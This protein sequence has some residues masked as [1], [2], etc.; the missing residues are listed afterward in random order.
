M[1][2]RKPKLSLFRDR[3]TSDSWTC[4]NNNNNPNLLRTLHRDKKREEDSFSSDVSDSPVLEPRRGKKSE[5]KKT[6][7]D[8]DL[9][10][11]PER[12][13]R[14]W[15]SANDIALSH[16]SNQTSP[17][18]QLNAS[19][20]AIPPE[21]NPNI[22]TIGPREISPSSSA[23]DASTTISREKR[24]AK[25]LLHLHIQ[26]A[27]T[28]ANNVG[29]RK[30]DNFYDSA[31][32]LKRTRKRS[33]NAIENGISKENLKQG[34]K[35][36]EK[37]S[38]PILVHYTHNQLDEK[39]STSSS[40][41]KTKPF[42]FIKKP[43]RGRS[44]SLPEKIWNDFLS[45]TGQSKETIPSA[46]TNTKKKIS[47]DRKQAQ[48]L[49]QQL[50]KS[51]RKLFG[52]MEQTP[53]NSFDKSPQDNSGRKEEN[54]YGDVRFA[55]KYGMSSSAEKATSKVG[56]TKAPRKISETK[57]PEVVSSTSKTSR[58]SKSKQ[59][60]VKPKNSE[61]VS[62]SN[63]TN[64]K[65][66]DKKA[67]NQP[68]KQAVKKDDAKVEAKHTESKKRPE[69]KTVPK[70]Q[71]Q[72]LKNGETL[73]K[74]KS[75]Q[76]ENVPDV[77]TRARDSDLRENTAAS[78]ET[79]EMRSEQAEEPPPARRFSK[80]K[81]FKSAFRL[82]KKSN[83]RSI[84]FDADSKSPRDHVI[85]ANM[86][87]NPETGTPKKPKRP[88]TFHGISSV[89][90]TNIKRL[91]ASLTDPALYRPMEKSEVA[92]DDDAEEVKFVRKSS[93]NFLKSFRIKKRNKVQNASESLIEASKPKSESRPIADAK[94]V[95]K[96]PEERRGLNRNEKQRR[97][98]S[99]NIFQAFYSPRRRRESSV[100]ARDFD[101][102]TLDLASG[103]LKKTWDGTLIT[104]ATGTDVDIVAGFPLLSPVKEIT[105]DIGTNIENDSRS[106][107]HHHHRNTSRHS[108]PDSPHMLV[109]G[110]KN[111]MTRTRG[112]ATANAPATVPTPYRCNS[113]D[114]YSSPVKVNKAPSSEDVSVIP[115]SS[116]LVSQQL[117]NFES[118]AA[119]T[120]RQS[121]SDRECQS[122]GS[123]TDIH[124][125]SEHREDYDNEDLQLHSPPWNSRGLLGRVKDLHR[126][127]VFSFG[128]S[129]GNSLGSLG[130]KGR[131]K[132][133]SRSNS[134]S[135]NHT[136]G[137]NSSSCSSSSDFYRRPSAPNGLGQDRSTDSGQSQRRGGEMSEEKN[138]WRKTDKRNAVRK[139]SGLGSVSHHED[140]HHHHP[141]LL[142]PGMRSEGRRRGAEEFGD[143]EEEKQGGSFGRNSSEE[144][145]TSINNVGAGP[146]N[147]V[148][149]AA[150]A[151][152]VSSRLG[153]R[154]SVTMTLPRHGSG[155][156]NP[157]SISSSLSDCEVASDQSKDNEYDGPFVGKALAL[158]DCIPSPYDRHALRYKKGDVIEIISKKPT[159]TWTGKIGGRVGHFKFINVQVLPEED[160][161]EDVFPSGPDD[162][163]GDYSRDEDYYYNN[164]ARF[165]DQSDASLPRR[166]RRK[167]SLTPWQMEQ[168]QSVA[169]VINGLRK[170][171]ALLRKGSELR[172]LEIQGNSYAREDDGAGE[173]CGP[174]S[175]PPSWSESLWENPSNIKGFPDVRRTS[176]REGKMRKEKKGRPKSVRDL[177][178]RINLGNYISVFI[179][180]GFESLDLFK[181]LEEEDLDRL[182]IVDGADR[183]KILTAAELLREYDTEEEIP[184]LTPP[185]PAPE[186]PTAPPPPAFSNYPR[187]SGIFVKFEEELE[188]HFS[189]NLENIQNSAAPPV[190]RPGTYCTNINCREKENQEIILSPAN[191]QQ[192]QD[193]KG[194]FSFLNDSAPAGAAPRC[195]NSPSANGQILEIV[196]NDEDRTDFY[197]DVKQRFLN[198][199]SMFE[200]AS[201]GGNLNL[202][203]NSNPGA[204]SKS[205]ENLVTKTRFVYEKSDSGISCSTNSPT[206]V[207]SD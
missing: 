160:E 61:V 123:Q 84:N 112:I 131:S 190:P 127:G 65:R 101:D 157:L 116:A 130:N 43:Q 181:E 96:G 152:T 23:S 72:T 155:P 73:K 83:R 105:P 58:G 183:A 36:K 12:D 69:A 55:S 93:G 176:S 197:G 1:T 136:P 60:E 11:L 108:S 100:T 110:A 41:G 194:I 156:S 79:I 119:K 153:T 199:R 207:P 20:G 29:R 185:A 134:R 189:G 200:M 202:A 15:Y 104:N 71:I 120:Q 186:P 46:S 115:S 137:R 76:Q 53:D 192:L 90:K 45:N 68:A 57:R 5:S 85:L 121:P 177:L 64:Q 159:G 54:P 78:D 140:H 184:I 188:N 151:P 49:Q 178:E 205:Q 118:P 161:D 8:F 171:N 132:S 14:F 143:S 81:L 165:T 80:W 56:D 191:L 196:S 141:P 77:T 48:L 135:A 193:D 33:R 88:V 59:S 99:G 201:N 6:R 18:T 38:N 7:E 66:D 4:P 173:D 148:V 31:Q 91:S 128:S 204:N 87:F 170:E 32:T 107:H 111:E 164:C 13:D 175:M 19:E 25:A 146:G 40:K 28:V 102:V 129:S 117:Q 67:K 27:E 167:N 139:G 150:A 147:A 158:V 63:N 198:A 124:I 17:P 34:S 50:N 35:L 122:R 154:T 109:K 82:S 195:G 125:S 187:D 21:L 42:N 16:L 51:S 30:S 44:L 39:N 145:L 203:G 166:R 37:H 2:G 47:L 174:S 133:S 162:Y 3:R 97:S 94:V 144:E 9:V 182:A 172:S 10:P 74:R 149:V 206:L 163:E 92:S 62:K 24:I 138:D 95:S 126:N 26:A 22:Q 103:E 89:E 106:H 75:S 169:S 113:P 168:R 180:H 98:S 86:T 52:K 70:Q 179:L 114:L 142:L